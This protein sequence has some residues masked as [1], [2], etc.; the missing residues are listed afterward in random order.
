VELA[1][2][3]PLPVS[4][5]SGAKAAKRQEMAHRRK[6]ANEL[7]LS[8]WTQA[9]VAEQLGVSPSTLSSD[10]RALREEWRKENLATTAQHI[11]RELTSLA[12]DERDARDGLAASV[13]QKDKARWHEVILKIR[14]RRAKLLGLDAPAKVEQ[15]TVL[16]VEKPIRV[17]GDLELEQL[18]RQAA[19]RAY[20][21][22]GTERPVEPKIETPA[23]VNG[24][25]DRPHA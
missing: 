7:F 21:P 9:E 17:E 20:G 1:A 2:N 5:A 23:A 15:K 11:D 19:A 10:L 4:P 25:D 18:V 14:D 12:M 24:N 13:E 22:N 16:E 6:R 3:V 8:G